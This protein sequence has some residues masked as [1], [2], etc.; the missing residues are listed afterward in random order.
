MCFSFANKS[1]LPM[2]I[3]MYYTYARIARKVGGIQRPK[4]PGNDK[5]YTYIEGCWRFKGLRLPYNIHTIYAPKSDQISAMQAHALSVALYLS[6]FL[7]KYNMYDKYNALAVKM[8]IHMS[9]N[10]K[11]M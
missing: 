1:K 5:L 10:N 8:Y 4:A 11:K 9:E 6:F 7:C 3:Y 2:Y